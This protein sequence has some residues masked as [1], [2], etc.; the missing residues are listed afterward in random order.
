MKAVTGVIECQVALL[1]ETAEVVFDPEL[2]QAAAIV[3]KLDSL[4]YSASLLRLEDGESDSSVE[5]YTLAVGGMS[6]AACSGKIER[7]VRAMPGVQSCVVALSTNTAK[8]KLTSHLVADN[9]GEALG[10]RDVIEK[11]IS[12]GYEAKVVTGSDEI[13]SMEES[14]ARET[15]QW[16]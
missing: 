15:K 14:H 8:V 6:C 3:A 16:R 1:A 12:L 13:G 4:G 9:M 2:I 10:I 11:I 7:T 5:E